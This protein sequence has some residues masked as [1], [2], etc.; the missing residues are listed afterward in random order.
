MSYLRNAPNEPKQTLFGCEMVRPNG[1]ALQ[2]K[3]DEDAKMEGIGESFTLPNTFQ[4]L[5]ILFRFNIG[6]FVI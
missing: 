3:R 2:H 5:S 4:S 6:E 1:V